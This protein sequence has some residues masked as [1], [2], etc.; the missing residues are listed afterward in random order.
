[1]IHIKVEK[2]NDYLSI[3]KNNLLVFKMQHEIV[4]KQFFK[5]NKNV[6]KNGDPNREII[7]KYKNRNG[8]CTFNFKLKSFQFIKLKQ[9]ILA[10]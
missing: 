4:K 2:K 7:L 6:R 5:F 3:Y 8:L 1:M 10:M 9:E